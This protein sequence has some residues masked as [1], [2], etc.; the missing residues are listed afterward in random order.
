MPRGMGDGGLMGEDGTF[1]GVFFIHNFFAVYADRLAFEAAR[2]LGYEA[3]LPELETIVL[4]GSSD[5]LA[6]LEAGA[7]QEDGYRWIPGVPGYTVGSRWGALYSAFP[8]QL[9]PADHPLVTGTIRKIESQLSP[10]GIPMNTGWLQDG[11]W[12]AI[13]LDNLAEVLLRRNEG[14]KAIAYLLA[15]LEHG[16]PLFSWCEERG[17]EPNTTRCTGDRQHLWTPLSVSRFL[18][19]ALVMEDERTLHLAR[20]VERT[21]LIQPGG[22]GVEG[23]STWFGQLD[24][25]LELNTQ[26]GHL[27][28]WI[29]MEKC[30]PGRL[31]LHLRL[32]E[33]MRIAD[34]RASGTWEA[35]SEC[36]CWDHPHGMVEFS[37][38]VSI[39]G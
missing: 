20:G 7:I 18:R 13:T 22:V 15:T 38:K 24:Y 11:M 29:N 34:I 19:D 10:G 16:T 30:A 28:G 14:D 39:T 12:V 9:L 1:Y 32:P 21:W 6:A 8:C 26:T 27:E 23:M 2:I 25:H 17:P 4:S 5:L 33:K 31:V 37:A 35:D 36:L 3:D